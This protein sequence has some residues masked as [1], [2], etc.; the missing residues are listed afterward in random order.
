M[1]LGA[2]GFVLVL[3]SLATA[4]PCVGQGY[5]FSQRGSVTQTVAFTDISV[6]YGR[7]VARGR[8]L[9]PGLVQWGQTWNP[10]ADSA[11]R[12]TISRDVTLEGRPVN[13][14]TYSLWLIPR[15]TAPWT[16]ILSRAGHVFHTP[17]PGDSLDAL[18]LDVAIERGAHMETLAIYF[19]VVL[20]EEA[21][22]RIH[23]G[24]I[25]VPLRITAPY[26]PAP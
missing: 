15:E 22:M 7:P 9:F 21:V 24:E 1:V 18:R 6:A 26:R 2:R 19:P 16:V 17:Y 13:A 5:P 20:R 14:G 11:T 10:G 23:W 4:T 3:G 12:M 25:I 8:V